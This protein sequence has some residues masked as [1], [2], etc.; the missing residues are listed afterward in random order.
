MVVGFPL[1]SM[2]SLALFNW[3][4]FWYWYNLFCQAS[5]KLDGCWLQDVSA[6]TVSPVLSCHVGHFCGSW[7]SQLCRTVGWFCPLEACMAT[8]QYHESQSSGGFGV[9]TSSGPPS[10]ESEV[11][12][13]FSNRHI[14][15]SFVEASKS[16]LSWE[17]LGLPW[18]AT[19]KAVFHAC[20]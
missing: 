3:L 13:I 9:R 14:P 19:W 15:F 5:L 6:T 8:F 10:P 18:Q 7:T 4:D 12:D 2:T 11:Y 1:R 16:M 20:Y 17:S